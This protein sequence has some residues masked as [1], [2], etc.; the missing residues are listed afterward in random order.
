[1]KRELWN[2]ALDELDDS[3]IEEAGRLL[4]K[5][6]AK[7]RHITLHR[8]AVLAAALCL[9]LSLGGNVLA[10]AWVQEREAQLA[11]QEDFYVRLVDAEMRDLRED[12]FDAEKFFSALDSSDTETVYIAVNRLVECY[13]DPALRAR[14]IEAVAPF[15]DSASEMVA[16]S[17]RRVLSILNETYDDGGVFVMA[18]GSVVFTLFPGLEE[19][20]AY[21]DSTL[22]RIQDGVL[23]VYWA[24]DEPYRVTQQIVPSPDGKKLAIQMASNKSAFL[25]IEDFVDGLVSPELMN[26]TL[27]TARAARGM[28]LLVRVDFETYSWP[29][30][31]RW[32]D[33]DTLAFDAA[34]YFAPE[35]ETADAS[36]V[37]R[38]SDRALDVTLRPE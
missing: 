27:M 32:L 18:D 24:L 16:Q 20:G 25:F 33:G 23:D 8:W 22:W 31:L 9:L 1:M 17:A 10:V 5:P 19:S 26:S 3:M 2:K 11:A 4:D 28:P 34:L 15:V 36:V 29:E 37:Y 14:A 7:R 6:R 21:S 38:F 30:E 35:G 13:N 12:A